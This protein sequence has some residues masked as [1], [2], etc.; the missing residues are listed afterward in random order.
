M[1]SVSALADAEREAPCEEPREDDVSIV[2]VV[3]DAKLEALRVTH[4]RTT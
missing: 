4:A 3:A 2:S 1:S